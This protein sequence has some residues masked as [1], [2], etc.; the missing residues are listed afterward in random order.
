MPL[1]GNRTRIGDPEPAIDHAAEQI[2]LAA[3]AD[4]RRAMV[5]AGAKLAGV[6]VD[7]EVPSVVAAA[8]ALVVRDHLIRS[9]DAAA[10][11]LV[12]DAYRTAVDR[13]TPRMEAWRRIGAPAGRKETGARFA[14]G[15][16]RSV[17]AGGGVPEG[18]GSASL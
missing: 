5:A 9:Y 4:V 2:A 1:A 18:P 16:K 11:S 7:E 6:A 8:L 13:G 17:A 10:L 15:R 14:F 3:V 12:D